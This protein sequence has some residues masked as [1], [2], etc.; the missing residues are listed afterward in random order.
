MSNDH[1]LVKSFSCKLHKI[2][3]PFSCFNFIEK[4]YDS[5]AAVH[6]CFS[7]ARAF[8]AKTLIVEDIT[9]AGFILSENKE[10]QAMFPKYTCAS[11]QKLSFWTTEL[12]TSDEISKCHDDD[13][14]GYLIIKCDVVNNKKSFHIFESVFRKYSHRHNC[15]PCQNLYP[16]NIGGKQFSI[17]GVLY[18][19]QNGF[20]KACAHVA[21]RSL[22][23]RL[24]P[25]GDLE[26]SF[27]NKIARSISGNQY[28]PGEGLNV[29]HMQKV[30]TTLKIPYGDLDYSTVADVDPDIRE[31]VPYQKFLYAGVESGC[32]GLLGFKMD[33]PKASSGKHIIPFYGHTFNKDTWTPDADAHYFNIGGGIGYIPSESWTSSFIGHDD[34]FGPNFCVPR[35]YVKPEQAEYVIELRKPSVKYGGMIAEVQALQFLYSITPYFD[36]DGEWAKRLAFYSSKESQ[37]VVLRAVC[38]EKNKYLN[39][40]KN[41]KDWDGNKENP[42]F[43]NI[44][45][46]LLPNILW[47][48]EISLPQL[49]PANERKLG[50]IIMNATKEK[51]DKKGI[52]YNLFLFARLPSQYISLKRIAKQ[53]PEFSSTPSSLISHVELICH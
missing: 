53:G 21:L 40:L 20:N 47:V 41:I 12:L 9:E 32:G 25:E 36:F 44:L 38:I 39:H 13:L 16:V 7:L 3:S 51:N 43:V 2:G 6:R 37:K 10:L 28:L 33:G 34:N 46:P 5:S 42:F 15:V 45:E 1:R 49:F 22:L 4:N 26:Y 17:S 14:I 24:L 29:E 8:D 48:V 11:I 27:I 30:L 31:R 35:L 18:C 23:S 50:D 19:Q 52:D